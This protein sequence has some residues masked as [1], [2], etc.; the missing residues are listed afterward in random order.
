MSGIGIAIGT[1]GVVRGQAAFAPLRPLLA[2][3]ATLGYSHAELGSAK[4]LG[5]IVG[6][7]LQ[8]Q[9]LAALQAAL[10]GSAVRLTLHGSAV[11]STLVGNLMDVAGPI[12]RAIV[13][14][15]LALAAAIGAE[16]LVYHRG[17]PGIPYADSAAIALAL[18]AERDALRALGD[19]AGRHGIRIAV[20]N[21]HPTETRLRHQASFALEALGEHVARIDHPQVGICLDTGHGFLSSRFYGFDF[22]SQVRAIAPLVNHIHLTDNLGRPLMAEDMHPDEAL[23]LGL[24]D[25]HLLPGWGTIPL[26]GVFGN[27]FPRAPI[28]TLEIRGQFMPHA[29]EALTTTRAL[30]ALIPAGDVALAASHPA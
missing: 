9:R 11:S 5:I 26:A 25:L 16:V 27:A 7:Q 20:E 12:Q 29:G 21:V 3:V 2:E 19:E 23:A 15:D 1:G 6:G 28:I 13:A 22:L 14:A 17:M 10:A 18:D 4:S 30:Q 24:G 8:P